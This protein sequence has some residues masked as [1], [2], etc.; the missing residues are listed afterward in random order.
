[1]AFRYIWYYVTTILRQNLKKQYCFKTRSFQLSR[2]EYF[3]FFLV[4]NFGTFITIL[5][6]S[7]QGECKGRIGPKEKDVDDITV[8]WVLWVFHPPVLLLLFFLSFSLSSSNSLFVLIFSSFF[9]LWFSLIFAMRETLFYIK[10]R[11]L[12]LC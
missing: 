10:K 5:R 2:K 6:L 12:V 3:R 4:S 1:M 8:R 9:C 7:T 11:L